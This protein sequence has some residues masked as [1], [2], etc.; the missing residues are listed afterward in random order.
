MGKWRNALI[1]V[2]LLT[3]LSLSAGID[4]DLVFEDSFE[5]SDPVITTSPVLS[6][7]VDEFYTYDVDAL[8]PSGKSLLYLLTSAPAGMAIN[9]VSGV[10]S[11]VPISIGNFPIEVDVSNGI[12]GATSQ[13]WMI[14]VEVANDTD[15]DG[16]SDPREIFHGTDP[17][18]PDSDDDGL[19]DGDEVDIHGTDPTDA[20]SD[21]DGLP[22][23]EEINTFNTFP[24]NP[25]TDND[26][27]GDG[28][29]IIAT[30]DPLDPDDFPSGPPDPVVI[31]PLV[32]PTV[33]ST[34]F[35]STAFLYD[36]DPA[37]QTGVMEGTIE[38]TRAAVLRG[39]VMTRDALPLPGAVVTIKDHPEYGQTI[40]RADG[41]YDMVVNGGEP[42]TI[43]FVASGFLPGQRLV[44]VEWQNYHAAPDMALI[45]LDIQVT[46]VDLTTIADFQVAQGSEI[47]DAD[48]PRQATVLFPQG[49]T[50]MMRLPDD[51]M[52]PITDL[53]VRATEYTVGE[54]GPAAMPGE[55][56]PNSAYTYAVELSIDEAMMAGA[57]VVEF[58]QP[59][60]Y[61]V[62]NFLGF[63]SGIEVPSGFYDREIGA[64]IA[65][66]NGLVIDIIDEVG[67]L[68]ILDIDD[69][70]TPADPG[71]LAAL[72]IT[73]A[74]R[75]EMAQLYD[76]GDSIWRVPIDH[77]SAWDANWGFSPPPDALPPSQSGLH[78]GPQDNEEIDCTSDTYGSII[79]CQNQVLGESIPLTGTRSSLNYR[80]DRSEGN[81][82]ASTVSLSLSGDTVPASL[83]GIKLEINVAGKTQTFD[84]PP[85]TN[86]SMSF[87]WDGK[88]VYGRKLQ[89]G[90][91][92][93]AIISYRYQGVYYEVER[94][95]Y[96]GNGTE[97]V[98]S[99][100]REEVLLPERYHTLLK[101]WSAQGV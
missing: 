55:L 38:P 82:T 97:I 40:S 62:D 29:E 14:T 37:I 36:G 60:P 17:N 64:W 30:T 11:W 53:S 69:S 1:L 25:D 47:T 99:E 90:Q 23:G 86:Q 93:E 5:S 34:V 20:D 72:G 73:D 96:R 70:G 10:I 78:R 85:N 13:A 16:L 18:D 31:A 50:A 43:D 83:D 84:Y 39:Y 81:R 51:S 57:E 4:P 24:T 77:F 79:E 88:D 28:M 7:R 46:A 68:A 12:G 32:D 95:G 58:S 35:D 26:L 21:S 76:P 66:E 27:Y 75:E 65:S 94:F 54:N 92:L 80:S 87:T 6:G 56:P 45:P 2:V 48:G 19:N 52:V 101:T 22:D 9:P 63:P 8:D 49:T 3:T 71:A 42:L 67:G 59:I 100:V 44:H 89:G 61:Y 74:E 91:P 41:M 15:G 33:T 98:G